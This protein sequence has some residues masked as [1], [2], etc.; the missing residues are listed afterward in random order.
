MGEPT[1]QKGW[2]VTRPMLGQSSPRQW[3][4]SA[5]EVLSVNWRGEESGRELMEGAVHRLTSPA[6]RQ[7]WAGSQIGGVG[8]GVGG[9]GHKYLAEEEIRA[10]K[11]TLSFSPLRP[12]SMCISWP[13]D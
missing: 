10:T 8:V 12:V 9:G 2:T 7:I 5:S 11:T 1:V 4:F 3:V 13:E 6:G